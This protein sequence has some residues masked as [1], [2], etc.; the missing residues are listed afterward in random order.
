ML[1]FQR[2][3]DQLEKVQLIVAELQRRLELDNSEE[4]VIQLLNSWVELMP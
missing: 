1:N 4:A 2:E 3:R